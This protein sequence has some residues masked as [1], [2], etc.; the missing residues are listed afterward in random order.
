M[1]T[2]AAT[3]QQN[4]SNVTRSRAGSASEPGVASLKEMQSIMA[5]LWWFLQPVL[6]CLI[7]Q[8]IFCAAVIRLFTR[9]CAPTKRIYLLTERTNETTKLTAKHRIFAAIAW[10]PKASVQAAIGGLVL[11]AARQPGQSEFT[12]RGIQVRPVRAKSGQ[13]RMLTELQ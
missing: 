5:A 7:V 4:N 1:P 12:E 6:F 13:L 3:T 8:V 2:A 10:M 9:F 11:D